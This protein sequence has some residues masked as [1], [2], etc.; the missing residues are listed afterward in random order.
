[1]A[2]LV[3]L[4][5][6]PEEMSITDVNGKEIFIREEDVKGLVGLAF[7]TIAQIKIE[8][9]IQRLKLKTNRQ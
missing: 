3:S 2:A 4:G 8:A 5:I 9:R 1:M 6:F 7:Q